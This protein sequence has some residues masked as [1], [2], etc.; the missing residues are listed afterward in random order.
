MNGGGRSRRE[1]AI[2]S[3]ATTKG[4]SQDRAIAECVPFAAEKGT[5]SVPYGPSAPPTPF[6]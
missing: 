5:H 2:E 6:G 3:N 4:W 1:H